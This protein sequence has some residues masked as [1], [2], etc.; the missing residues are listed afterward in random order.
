MDEVKYAKIEF[1]KGKS[2][3]LSLDKWQAILKSEKT[4]VPYTLDNEKQWTGRT[5][6]KAEVVRSEYDREYSEKMN[7]ADYVLYRRLEDDVIV[8]LSPGQVLDD[9]SKYVQVRT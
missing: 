6:N 7:T 1:R 3:H 9:P 2:I 8:K 5:L 4:L